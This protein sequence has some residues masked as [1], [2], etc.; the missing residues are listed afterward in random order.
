MRRSPFPLALLAALVAAPAFAQT[1]TER[2]SACEPG[3]P[4]LA[5]VGTITDAE[6]GHPLHGAVVIVDD[7]PLGSADSV[8]CYTV[9][10]A[11]EIMGGRRHVTVHMHRYQAPDTMVEISPDHSDTVHFALR[12]VAPGC[13]L[14]EGEWSLRLMLDDRGETGVRPRADEVEG[15][16]VFSGRLP[17]GW[18]EEETDPHMEWGRFDVDLSTFFGGPYARD[19]STTTFGPVTGDF[20]RQAVGEVLDDDSVMMV[21][22]PGMSHGGLS[23]EGTIRGDTV[24][25]KWIQNAYCCGARGRFVMH[26]VPASPTGDSLIV[27]GIRIDAEMR[28]AAREAEAARAKR[29]GY[30]R[31]R[32]FDESTGNYAP[33][34]FAAAG[35]ETNPGGYT[36]RG[37]YG[38]GND[39]WGEEHQFEPGTYDLLVFRYRCKGEERFADEDYVENRMERITVTIQSGQ[40]VDKDIRL[41]LCAIEPDDFSD[42]PPLPDDDPARR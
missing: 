20:F 22:I 3:A 16:M 13:C 34:E 39:G 11:D 14:L 37:H 28:E 26:R 29:V 17:S 38:S 9:I 7:Y 15:R 24:H 32:V 40:R 5:L 10:G 41:D 23:L 2:M 4:G 35:H 21:M 8:G 6:T 1:P 12:S 36:Y 19:V 18:D 31:L 30:L 42:L 33:V 25:G 27:R